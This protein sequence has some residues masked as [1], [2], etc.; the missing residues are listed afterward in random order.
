MTQENGL[1]AKPARNSEEIG[2]LQD[3]FSSLAQ[4]IDELFVRQYDTIGFHLNDEANEYRRQEAHFSRLMLDESVSEE[5]HKQCAER[6]IALAHVYQQGF[7][8][9]LQCLNEDVSRA[10]LDFE[11]LLRRTSEQTHP[12][13]LPAGLRQWF[14]LSQEL[15]AARLMATKGIVD[16]VEFDQRIPKMIIDQEGRADITLSADQSQKF[17]EENHLSTIKGFNR[18]ERP[19]GV[20]LWAL[21]PPSHLPVRTCAPEWA[22]RG[23]F[24]AFL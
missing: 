6:V 11:E 9:S 19:P 12:S 14:S 16:Q 18:N 10:I 7:L 15:Q 20:Q 13:N 3:S 22:K 2:S 5:Q 21:L 4:K 24:S 1:G 23:Q 8:R 17:H